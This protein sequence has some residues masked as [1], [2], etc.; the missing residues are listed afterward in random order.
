MKI[1]ELKLPPWIRVRELFFQ[2]HWVVEVRKGI[3]PFY[4][5]IAVDAKNP[6]F[7]WDPCDK[8]YRDC[9]IHDEETIFQTLA[10]RGV[11]GE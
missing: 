3:W 8:F 2:G 7:T 4:S 1:E 10:S 11:G 6:R 5:W 9:I